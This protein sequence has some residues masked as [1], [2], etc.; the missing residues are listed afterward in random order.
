MVL[1]FPAGRV[2]VSL[3]DLQKHQ[4]SQI[5]CN[6]CDKCWSWSHECMAGYICVL[7]P[8]QHLVGSGCWKK[9]VPEELKD[10]CPVC[11]VKIEGIETVRI[12]RGYDTAGLKFHKKMMEE[13]DIV[14]EQ[15]MSVKE[16]MKKGLTALDVATILYLVKLH[17]SLDIRKE[18]IGIF[19]TSGTQALT[20]MHLDRLVSF[21]THTPQYEDS[22]TEGEIEIALHA[23]N[24]YRG[25][26][27]GLGDLRV[28]V[29][30]PTD[31]AKILYIAESLKQLVKKL[32]RVL[33]QKIEQE[34]GQQ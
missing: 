22:R 30:S 8:C 25:T 4:R 24:D 7:H 2:S 13:L 11:K 14:E 17:D 12:F 5:A 34:K 21:L 33:P 6:V 16:K 15:E 26:N 9:T 3:A 31:L 20:E 18:R 19:F 27:F 23:F 1:K 32:P 28:A 29:S 10:R